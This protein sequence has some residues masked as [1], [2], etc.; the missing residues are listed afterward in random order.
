MESL[1]DQ[2]VVYSTSKTIDVTG[3]ANTNSTS[4]YTYIA[5]PAFYG[6]I[7][8][9]RFSSNAGT[10][11]YHS[12]MQI[13]TDYVYYFNGLYTKWDVYK[14]SNYGPVPVGE[15]VTIS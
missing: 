4:K 11:Q 7:S 14:F 13:S 10:N 2:T 15:G 6:N 3:N 8:D 5:Y 9:I 1:E 12:G